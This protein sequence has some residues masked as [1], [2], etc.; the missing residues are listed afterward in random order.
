MISRDEFE[1]FDQEVTIRFNRYNE[2]LE[3]HQS[4]LAG[5]QAEN[6]VL[7]QR[8][9]TVI[10]ANNNLALR[11][12]ALEQNVDGLKTRLDAMKRDQEYTFTALDN[13]NARAG[14]A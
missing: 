5:L 3:S 7:R 1:A 12:Q 9:S 14:G 8:I 2:V 13:L 4:K 6:N 10:E 11:V